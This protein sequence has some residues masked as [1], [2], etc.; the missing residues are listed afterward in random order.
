VH[1]AALAARAPAVPAGQLGQ[2]AQDRDP[3]DVR[4]TV[5]PGVD[6]MNQFRP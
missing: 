4:K 6:F 1:R 5:T 2:H 3:H